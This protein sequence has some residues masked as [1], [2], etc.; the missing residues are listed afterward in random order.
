[1]TA[2]RRP[3]RCPAVRRCGEAR[4][5]SSPE[6]P[7]RR[8]HG[9]VWRRRTATPQVRGARA[10]TRTAP[11]REE[12]SAHRRTRDEISLKA[13]STSLDKRAGLTKREN[14][15][16]AAVSNSGRALISAVDLTN[17]RPESSHPETIGRRPPAP[18]PTND[19]SPP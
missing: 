17:R 1:R 2:S 9:P 18:P 10:H 3:S 12:P 14:D 16:T 11:E 8:D 4:P 19:R 6:K 7:P 15:C 5:A 13:I